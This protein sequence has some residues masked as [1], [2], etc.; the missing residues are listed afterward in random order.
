VLSTERISSRLVLDTKLHSRCRPSTM[1]SHSALAFLG[2][3]G[4]RYSKS[5]LTADRSSS[6]L[7]GIKR[8]R[9]PKSCQ[10]GSVVVE[11]A[12]NKAEVAY[13]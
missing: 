8:T 1:S 9:R 3:G 7:F 13:F 10:V 2:S 5:V 4:R 11:F 12:P 6:P